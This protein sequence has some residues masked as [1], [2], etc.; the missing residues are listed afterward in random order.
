MAPK[1]NRRQIWGYFTKSA[2]EHDGDSEVEDW[3]SDDDQ[4]LDLDDIEASSDGMIARS[5][6]NKLETMFFHL[7]DTNETIRVRGRFIMSDPWWAAR[8]TVVEHN[9]LWE[10]CGNV[11]YALR[12]DHG[13][14]PLFLTSCEVHPQHLQIFTEA[15]RSIGKTNRLTFKTLPELLGKFAAMSETN[16]NMA[17]TIHRQ[18]TVILRKTKPT[19]P[20]SNDSIQHSIPACLSCAFGDAL[21]LGY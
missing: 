4:A 3:V 21:H 11:S 14:V 16:R 10:L 20:G 9:D 17:D 2:T 1:K 18:I 12:D 5:M 19:Y 8:M 15:M 6:T 7:Y 13:V